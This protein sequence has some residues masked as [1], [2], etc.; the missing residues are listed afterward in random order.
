[1]RISKKI[2]LF[3]FILSALFLVSAGAVQAFEGPLPENESRYFIETES[4]IIKHLFGAHHKFDGGFSA[5]LTRGE[6]WALDK[7]FKVSFRKITYYTVSEVNEKLAISGLN[8]L[9]EAH[10]ESLEDEELIKEKEDILSLENQQPTSQINWGTKLI[11]G[12]SGVENVNE[13]EGVRVALLD[14]GV[15]KNHPD[16]SN[17][18]TQCV[19]FTRSSITTDTCEDKN[20]HGTY[21]AGIIAADGGESGSGMFGIAP[22]SE[23]WAYKV[24]NQ[25][26]FCWADDVA[27]AL[28]YAIKENA[29][30]ANLNFGGAKGFLI[31]KVLINNTDKNTLLISSAGNRGPEMGTLNYPAAREEFLAVGAISEDIK[32]PDW[33]SRGSNNGDY[34]IEEGEIEFVAPGVNIESTWLNEEYRYL[35]GTSSAAPFIAGLA[36][37]IWDG[38]MYSS[39]SKL[40]I[41]AQDVWALGDDIATGFGLP[42]LSR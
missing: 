2:S 5:E 38:D 39:R 25:D 16:I 19:D 13:G 21:A 9:F 31:E 10:N 18:I 7:I 23:I 6:L 37:K 26:G 1:M 12:S 15:D 36:A 30:I 35:S 14:T 34:I 41:M 20:G 42:I 28:D 24:C 40:R 17:R 3:L 4:G 22:E 29:D 32:V 33:S 11:Y 27:K 8:K